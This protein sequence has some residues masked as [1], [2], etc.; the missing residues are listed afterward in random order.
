MK[1]E[2][3]KTEKENNK[4]KVVEIFKFFGGA[5]ISI[6]VSSIITNM[7]KSTLP[8]DKN[9][10]IVKICTGIGTF[11]IA[12]VIAKAANDIFE[13]DVDDICEII[14]KFK[15]GLAEQKID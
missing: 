15:S 3:K 12:T 11:F 14:N 2:I 13:Q 7:V 5:V 1:K 10:K 4:N 9:N 6:G 8:V